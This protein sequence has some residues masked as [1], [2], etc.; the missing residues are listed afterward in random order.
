MKQQLLESISNSNQIWQMLFPVHTGSKHRWVHSS[1]RQDWSHQASLLCSGLPQRRDVPLYFFSSCGCG[2]S[3]PQ[4]SCSATQGQ[5]QPYLSFVEPL[6]PWHTKERMP[7]HD[8]AAGSKM[9]LLVGDVAGSGSSEDKAQKWASLI[10]Y[11]S[12]GTFWPPFAL[13]YN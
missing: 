7:A 13:W 3:K 6:V 8:L 12:T 10:R 5:S 4:P 2:S 1:P 9:W 11:I